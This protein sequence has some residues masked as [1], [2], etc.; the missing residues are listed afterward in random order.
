MC[1]IKFKNDELKILE[2]LKN[3]LQ[4]FLFS[5]LQISEL[6]KKKNIRRGSK[7]FIMQY[8]YSY[9]ISLLLVG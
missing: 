4:N 9:Q 8:N 6:K 3:S 1:H 7:L 5:F 2:I